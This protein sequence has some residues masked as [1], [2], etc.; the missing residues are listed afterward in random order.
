MADHE[1]RLISDGSIGA[2]QTASYVYIALLQESSPRSIIKK[3]KDFLLMQ[4]CVSTKTYSTE[5]R[6]KVTTQTKA[7]LSTYIF[8]IIW[9][10]NS[11]LKDE[12]AEA[13]AVIGKMK[14]N[15]LSRS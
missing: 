11:E 5:V 13:T 3:Y 12:V 4:L 9:G 8:G 1:W 2:W 15:W 7:W 10:G 14:I 6:R